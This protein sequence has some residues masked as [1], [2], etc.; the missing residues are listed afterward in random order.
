MDVKTYSKYV[1]YGIEFGKEYEEK[2]KKLLD[3]EDYASWHELIQEM[4][5]HKKRIE[6]EVIVW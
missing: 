6:Q 2:L 1:Q 5:T 4:L 3:K